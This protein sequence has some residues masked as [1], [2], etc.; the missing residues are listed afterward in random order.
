MP[1][2]ESSQITGPAERRLNLRLITLAAFLVVDVMLVAAC[3]FALRQNVKLRGAV[4]ADEALLTPPNGTFVPPLIG[5]DWTGAPQAILYGHDPRPTLVYTFSQRCSYCQANWRGMRSL[6]ALA[7]RSLRII[8]VDTLD[9]KFTSQYLTAN[10]IQ[11]SALLTQ[12]P[13][14]TAYVYDARAVPQLLLVNRSGQV[15]WS[16]V[17]ELTSGDISKVLSL[18]QHD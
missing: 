13:S 5:T 11:Q 17:G 4:A 14:S 10:G 1:S 12:M 15:Q 7:P 6:Q 16:H 9:N 18:V 8:Y 2:H 3:L